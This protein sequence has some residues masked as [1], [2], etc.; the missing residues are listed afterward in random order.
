[1]ALVT[2]DAEEGTRGRGMVWRPEA[3]WRAPATLAATDWLIDAVLCRRVDHVLELAAGTGEA[4]IA[5][6]EFLSND[7]KVTITDGAAH[8]VAALR[9]WVNDVGLTNIDVRQMTMDAILLP[10]GAVQAI[11]SRFG[12]MDCKDI[13]MA[14]REAHRVLAPG[15]Q[16]ALAMW[17]CASLNPVLGVPSAVLQ[18]VDVGGDHQDVRSVLG[19]LCF[20][21]RAELRELLENAGFDSVQTRDLDVWFVFSSLHDAVE[22]LG[23]RPSIR[24]LLANVSSPHACALRQALVREIDQRAWALPDGRI[25]VPATVITVTGD[26]PPPRGGALTRVPTSG[27]SRAGGLRAT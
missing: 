2:S 17:S 9:A 8:R 14:L 13:A 1:M 22:T 26:R 20:S 27:T 10:D 16:L 11:F 15:G 25:A 23:S 5:V 6:A 21:D 12:L 24:P 19:S 18:G 4:G 7:A 3:P